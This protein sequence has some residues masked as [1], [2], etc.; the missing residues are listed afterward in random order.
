MSRLLRSRGLALGYL[1]AGA[2][3]IASHGGPLANPWL[4]LVAKPLP[5]ALLLAAALAVARAEGGRYPWGI[6][7]GLAFSLAGDVL[8]MLPGDLFVPGLLAFLLAHL[9][10][11]VAFTAGCRWLPRPLPAVALALVALAVMAFLWPGLGPQLRLPVVVYV[12]ALS[13]MAAQAMGRAGALGTLAARAAA[14]G[15]GLFVLSD[16]LLAVGRFRAPFLGNHAAVLV[17]YFAAQWLITSSLPGT[18]AATSH[19]AA[20][21]R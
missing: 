3:A 7:T 15:A 6:A 2:L 21:N 13:T 11:L 17:T 12:V 8:L 5:L 4:Y 20:G 16:A 18:A 19:A 9:A 14:W 1:A 10:Y